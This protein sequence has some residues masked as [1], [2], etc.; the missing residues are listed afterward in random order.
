VNLFSWGWTPSFQVGQCQLGRENLSASALCGEVRA[1]RSAGIPAETVPACSFG[2][3]QTD[4][5]C[6]LPAGNSALVSRR[7]TQQGSDSGLVFS[8]ASS[9]RA[10]LSNSLNVVGLLPW[11]ARAL[12]PRVNRRRYSVGRMMLITGA[13]S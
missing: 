6:T 12:F 8:R 7:V 4:P 1:R 5:K 11:L 13:L 9:R 3:S 2:P 10:S